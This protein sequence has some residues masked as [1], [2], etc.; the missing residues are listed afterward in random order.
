VDLDVVPRD[1]AVLFELG[2]QYAAHHL[3]QTL[4]CRWDALIHHGDAATVVAVALPQTTR[5]VGDLLNAVEDWLDRRDVPLIRF[6]LDSR[7]YVLQRGGQIAPAG[8][9]GAP[10]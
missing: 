9:H 6:H 5:D 7:L 4:W 2:D 8:P 1:S 3:C 10:S